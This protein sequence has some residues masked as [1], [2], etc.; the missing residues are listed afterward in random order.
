[1]TRADLI[2]AMA[3]EIAGQG[4]TKADAE[5]GLCDAAVCWC[6]SSAT[7]ALAALDAAGFVVVPKV[8]TPE[9]VRAAWDEG[10]LT[11]ESGVLVAEIQADKIYRAMIDAGRSGPKTEARLPIRPGDSVIVIHEPSP[12]IRLCLGAKVILGLLGTA[13]RQV[14]SYGDWWVSFYAFGSARVPA[15]WLRRSNHAP[16]EE[17][18]D[19]DATP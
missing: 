14:G 4:C 9:M 5:G 13:E 12:P 10:G 7:A 15:E 18:D 11:T 17:I 6:V 1:M 2:Q 3:R 19:A 16:P 8:A